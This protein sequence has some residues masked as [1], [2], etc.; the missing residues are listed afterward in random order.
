M[1]LSVIFLPSNSCPSFSCLAFTA[2]PPL[3]DVCSSYKWKRAPRLFS[4]IF[5]SKWIYRNDSKMTRAVFLWQLRTW[6]LHFAYALHIIM[7]DY[8]DDNM[9]HSC[10]RETARCSIIQSTCQSKQICIAP[11][12][13]CRRRIRS[14]QESEAYMLSWNIFTYK[15]SK[16]VQLPQLNFVKLSLFSSW[17]Q[18]T[19]ND[20]EQI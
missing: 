17:P 18:M 20:L 6:E 8:I 14:T 3:V 4:K 10:R 15:M 2:P 16:I 13:V 1:L 19:L 12:T 9:K 5:S 11:Y 7:R